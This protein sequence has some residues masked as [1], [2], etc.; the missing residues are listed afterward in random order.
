MGVQV[1]NNTVVN[2]TTGVMVQSPTIPVPEVTVG[3]NVFADN[4]TVARMLTT[5][6]SKIVSDFNAFSGYQV[7]AFFNGK[8]RT[9]DQ[10]CRNNGKDCHSQNNLDPL[11]VNPLLDD[12]HLQATSPL[13]GRGRVTGAPATDIDGDNRLV[14]GKVDIGADEVNLN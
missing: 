4:P 14:D 11:F 7:Y 2:N 5:E 1:L 6:M 13:I 9:L 12:Y 8:S 10:A 3:N